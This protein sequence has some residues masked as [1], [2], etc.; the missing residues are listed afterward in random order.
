MWN[1]AFRLGVLG[2][3]VVFLIRHSITV[4]I[5]SGSFVDAVDVYGNCGIRLLHSNTHRKV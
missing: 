3:T 5:F 1:Q 4:L 2:A